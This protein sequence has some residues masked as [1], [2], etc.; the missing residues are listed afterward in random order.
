M[1]AKIV[2]AVQGLISKV[3]L[4]EA[5]NNSCVDG[6]T[7]LLKRIDVLESKVQGLEQENEELKEKLEDLQGELPA[8]EEYVEGPS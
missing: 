8:G 5:A 3:K 6:L 4:L 2:Q 1:D 7:K